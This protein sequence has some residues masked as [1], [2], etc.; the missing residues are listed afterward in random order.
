MFYTLTVCFLLF[1]VQVP[2]VGRIDKI[3][4]NK[5]GKV[6]A[7]RERAADAEELLQQYSKDEEN[8]V[9]IMQ[10]F[11]NEGLNLK[12]VSIADETFMGGL[13]LTYL[14]CVF[15]YLR[16]NTDNETDLIIS[17]MCLHF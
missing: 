11:L 6:I 5:M 7:E 3:F 9:T 2:P 13:S 8:N 14:L 12:E 4:D 10:N 1:F 16:T 15:D 17:R